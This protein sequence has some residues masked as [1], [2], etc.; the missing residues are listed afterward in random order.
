MKPQSLEQVVKDN[1][2]D[3]AVLKT[4]ISE[5]EEAATEC[6]R[7]AAF[8]PFHPHD[9]KES[10]ASSSP[11]R[12]MVENDA[13]VA[14]SIHR[15]DTTE[16]WTSS[17]SSPLP[18]HKTMEATEEDI[19]LNSERLKYNAS[20]WEMYKRI[21]SARMKMSTPSVSSSFNDSS[22]AG[23]VISGNPPLQQQ[24]ESQESLGVRGK[25]QSSAPRAQDEPFDLDY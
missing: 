18:I 8:S 6:N 19:E 14:H 4:I 12:N 22:D 24:Q 15:R 7:R 2:D 23:K 25:R 10:R 3:C 20:T 16:S 13:V 17:T 5:E 11:S 1:D 21:T 9:P